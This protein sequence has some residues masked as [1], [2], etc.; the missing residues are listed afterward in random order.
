MLNTTTTTTALPT[1]T[2]GDLAKKLRVGLLDV[3]LVVR[4][5]REGSTDLEIHRRPWNGA[6]SLEVFPTDGHIHGYKSHTPNRGTWGTFSAERVFD[7]VDLLPKAAALRFVV[8]LDGKTN[9]YMETAVRGAPT[10][11]YG[12]DVALFE[13]LHG[14]A[15]YLEARFERRGKTVRKRFLLDTS[16]CPQNSARFGHMWH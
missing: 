6:H 7:V 10:N 13:G 12:L 11:R 5:H 8:E 14:D 15:L 1:I 4:F 9:Q 2:A 3:S 16:T